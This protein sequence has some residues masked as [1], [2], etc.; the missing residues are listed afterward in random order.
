MENFDQPL[1]AGISASG[2]QGLQISQEIRQY[3][4]QTSRW[5]L[6]FAILLFIVFG[7]VSLAGLLMIFAGNG[8][9]IFSGLLVIA[10]YTALF[11]FPG[12][13]YYLF[14]TQIKQALN[15]DDNQMLDQAFLN[16][17][18]FYRYVGILAIIFLSIY[19][20]VF[21]IYGAALTT[22]SGSLD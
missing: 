20:L 22:A 4:Q 16:L 1:D 21:L 18:K 5:A 7:I 9:G 6:F 2:D 3:W 8:P 10:I 11:F 14:S 17:R 12:W 13:Y 15:F 19:L